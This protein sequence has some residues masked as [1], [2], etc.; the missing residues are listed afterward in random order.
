MWNA[1]CVILK[2]SFSNHSVQKPMWYI[3]IHNV[4]FDV[5]TRKVSLCSSGE[6]LCGMMGFISEGNTIHYVTQSIWQVSNHATSDCWTRSPCY[7]S[8]GRKKTSNARILCLSGSVLM[9]GP[10]LTD[11]HT[12]SFW[13][14]IDG[15]IPSSSLSPRSGGQ[16]QTRQSK[17]NL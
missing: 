14:L 16:G 3:W 9:A 15:V 4:H 2:T 1:K 6:P 12:W 5:P 17:L 10:S 11:C 13:P 8:P 7:H